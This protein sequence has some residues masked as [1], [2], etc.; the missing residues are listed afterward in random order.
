[1]RWGNAMSSSL[2]VRP[3]VPT[4]GQP[5]TGWA[6]T[7]ASDWHMLLFHPSD[8]SDLYLALSWRHQ[9]EDIWSIRVCIGLSWG[10]ETNRW[11]SV[12]DRWA[13]DG[14]TASARMCWLVSQTATLSH[15]LSLSIHTHTHMGL[16]ALLTTCWTLLIPYK[17][18]KP[19][20]TLSYS[21]ALAKHFWER[22]WFITRHCICELHSCG[23]SDCEAWAFLLLLVVV[24]T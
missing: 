1:M 19:L 2:A 11:R 21:C 20:P 17:P 15:S 10:F 24:A 3:I 7:E 14:G 6:A 5:G 9:I 8:E 18:R 4:V 16:G 23:T 13:P 12:S 22:D